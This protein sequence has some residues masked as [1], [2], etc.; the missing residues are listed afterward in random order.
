MTKSGSVI[1]EKNMRK[2]V[3][4]I[5]AIIVA[6]VFFAQ[7]GLAQN[8]RGQSAPS[9][10]YVISAKAGGISLTEGTV[11]V[12]RKDG[13]SG[14]LIMGDEI[15]I[16]DRV[17]T[18]ADGRA[19]I[20]LNPGSYL[21]MAPNSSFE[22]LTTSLDDLKLRL[23]S[24]SAILEVYA[25][26]EFKIMVETPNARFNLIESGVFRVDVLDDGTGRI[27]VIQGQATLG[28]RSATV[29]KKG[30]VATLKGNVS[31][32][33]KFDRDRKDD[34]EAWS[35]ARSKEL[36]KA[37]EELARMNLRD[38]LM[39]SFTAGNWGMYDSFGLWV[40]NRV[41]RRYCF[42]PFGQGWESP[43]GFEFNA[44]ACY[45]HLPP[46]VYNPPH[47][48]GGGPA[49][50]PIVTAGDRSLIPPFVRL[51]GTS[52]G[53]TRGR[54]NMGSGGIFDSP[55]LGG[56]N[57]SSPPAP[58]YSPPAPVSAPPTVRSDGSTKTTKDN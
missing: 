15:A 28:D 57:Q 31:S 51:E 20:L 34:F 54:D 6:G 48:T 43:Y 49:L 50:T 47:V 32:I 22:F 58:V 14:H 25:A 39:N 18:G 26:N 12:M 27:A 16:G 24:G 30:R 23:E 38:P 42:L 11:T 10:N 29:V 55:P 56:A 37:S 3:L 44:C 17:T 21:R 33:T 53:A 1:Q 2:D 45:Y 7:A 9:D 46:I 35:K 52:G 4:R 36:A 8:N 40:L 5:L 13:G 41:T 19:E